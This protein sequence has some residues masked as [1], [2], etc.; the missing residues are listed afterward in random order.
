MLKAINYYKYKSSV[1]DVT[2]YTYFNT[3]GTEDS[4]FSEPNTK[5]KKEYKDFK[6][7]L[8]QIKKDNPQQHFDTNKIVF[9][10]VHLWDG[11]MEHFF[12]V[13]QLSMMNI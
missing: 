1:G 4:F 8:K 11:M 13:I 12:M 10:L 5:L 2:K 6:K 9:E 7:W 3:V